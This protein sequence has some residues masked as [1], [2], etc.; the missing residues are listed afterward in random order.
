M[1]ELEALYEESASPRAGEALLLARSV[2]RRD[3]D[4]VREVLDL[5]GERGDKP[6]RLL[7]L[8]T[9]AMADKAPEPWL[10]AAVEEA[11]E[12]G[13]GGRAAGAA[14]VRGGRPAVGAR[15][16]AALRD[17]A[18]VSRGRRRSSRRRARPRPWTGP[19]CWRP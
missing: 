6:L 8:E 15:G 17:A 12:L 5:A 1:S 19:S 11:Y 4:R 7:C 13:D 16:G 3:P 14:A 2:L 18:S 10:A 9:G